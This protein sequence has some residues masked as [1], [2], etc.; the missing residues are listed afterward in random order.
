MLSRAE[1]LTA[2]SFAKT[3]ADGK[4]ARHP[5]LSV[6]VFRRLSTANT[7][8][9]ADHLVRAAF[10]VPKKLAKATERNRLRR[11]IRECYRCHP[12]RLQ[13]QKQ[14]EGCDLIFVATPAALTADALQLNDALAQLL[15][16]AGHLAAQSLQTGS[17]SPNNAPA[18]ASQNAP[19]V[20]RLTERSVLKDVAKGH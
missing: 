1:R 4:T 17:L 11:Q 13:W 9:E 2:R 6:R 15:R 7:Q 16:R 8:H 18:A 5:L 20:E 10:V 3:F 19:P 14:L 12:A